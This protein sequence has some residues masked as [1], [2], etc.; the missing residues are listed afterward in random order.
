MGLSDMLYDTMVMEIEEKTMFF[1]IANPISNA[2][3]VVIENNALTY[4]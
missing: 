4:K 2:R 3:S 1:S